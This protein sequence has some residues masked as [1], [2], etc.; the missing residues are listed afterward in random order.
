[1]LAVVIDGVVWPTFLQK[2][3]LEQGA[4]GR[5]TARIARQEKSSPGVWAGAL[6]VGLGGQLLK[7][8]APGFS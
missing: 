6:G 1:M 4:E 3:S 7:P 8:C 2:V 5:D